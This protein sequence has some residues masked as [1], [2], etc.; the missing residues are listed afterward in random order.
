VGREFLRLATRPD[1]AHDV[2]SPF[3]NAERSSL[4][5]VGVQAADAA[6]KM[7]CS[8]LLLHD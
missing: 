3:I 7:R 6:E 8:G 4:A 5:V 1:E 2:K